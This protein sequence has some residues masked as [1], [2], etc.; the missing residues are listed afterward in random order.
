MRHTP[1]HPARLALI[2]LAALLFLS[3]G[4]TSAQTPTHV[5]VD[6][7]LSSVQQGKS[8][9]VR[10]MIENVSNLWA[11]DLK[12]SFPPSLLQVNAMRNGGFLDAGMLLGPTLDNEAGTAQLVNTQMSGSLPKSGSGTL[13]ELDFTA[14]AALGEGA[15]TIL[16]GD[17]VDATDYLLIPVEL[18]HGAVRVCD[19][20]VCARVFLPLVTR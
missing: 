1:S 20:A 11:Y 14:R 12:L 8:F 18:D 16:T 6:P 13:V 4:K 3:A 9:T 2:L 5:M 10:V 7:P 17:L 19:G 15:L